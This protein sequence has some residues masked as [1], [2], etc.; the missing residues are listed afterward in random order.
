MA[1]KSGLCEQRLDADAADGFDH[2]CLYHLVSTCPSQRIARKV[3][4]FMI[5][6]L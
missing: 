3:S 2:L 6:D 4:R 1:D 5:S